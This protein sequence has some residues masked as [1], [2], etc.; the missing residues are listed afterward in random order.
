MESVSVASKGVGDAI[1]GTISGAHES[2]IPIFVTSL[3]N[4]IAVTCVGITSIAIIKVNATFFNLK[5]YAV[6][7]QSVKLFL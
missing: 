4:P 7:K 3:K 1:D 6:K 2:Y 5:L